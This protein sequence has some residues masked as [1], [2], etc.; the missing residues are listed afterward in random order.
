MNAYYDCG[1]ALATELALK[2]DPTLCRWDSMKMRLLHCLE[3]RNMSRFP[4][5][6]KRRIPFGSR[7]CKSYSERLYCTCRMPNDKSRSMIACDKCNKWFHKHCMQ[8]KN[9]MS[10]KHKEWVCLECKNLLEFL[11]KVPVRTEGS[12]THYDGKVWYELVSSLKTVN[13]VA[14]AEMEPPLE[15]AQL[16]HGDKVTLEFEGK[17][18]SGEIDLDYSPPASLRRKHPGSTPP[19]LPRRKRPQSPHSCP[20]VS[21]RRNRPHSHSPPPAS[22][23][24]APREDRKRKA[25]TAS[26]SLQESK[27]AK[28]KFVEKK[29][30][31]YSHY[32]HYPHK[33]LR[34]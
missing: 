17:C 16:K 25:V 28:T 1:V 14:V 5:I 8:L 7:V 11:N 20:P 4:T 29:A 26:S 30:G 10:Y 2:S 9:S 21:P 31:V 22:N 12:G 13:G 6:V 18:F 15:K 32:C 34:N 24:S 19:A 27:R 23:S 33:N 3:N